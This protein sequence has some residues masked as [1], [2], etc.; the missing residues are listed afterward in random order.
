M[1][2]AERAPKEK[3]IELGKKLMEYRAVQTVKAIEAAR[4]TGSTSRQ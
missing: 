4:L 3:T 1:K 2:M